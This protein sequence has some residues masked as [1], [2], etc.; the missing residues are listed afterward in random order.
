M[1][2]WHSTWKPLRTYWSLEGAKIPELSSVVPWSRLRTIC[3][4][5]LNTTSPN[6]WL[7]DLD[8]AGLRL[9]PP[10]GHDVL[11]S[12]RQRVP[13]HPN[14]LAGLE[15]VEPAASGRIGKHRAQRPLASVVLQKWGVEEADVGLQRGVRQARTESST[16]SRS[17][18]VYFYNCNS[19]EVIRVEVHWDCLKFQLAP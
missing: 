18:G 11:L 9:R 10:D 2:L 13:T 5:P 6:W 7:L 1:K 12:K 3:S 8:Q 19:D 15:D 4:W 16:C 14:G 17:A